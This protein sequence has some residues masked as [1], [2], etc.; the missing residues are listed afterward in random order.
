[1]TNKN[2][3]NLLVL[4]NLRCNDIPWLEDKL[5][6]QLKLH[7][8]WTSLS[9]QNEILEIISHSVVQRITKDVQLSRNYALI[10]DKTS[11]ISCT[12]LNVLD[13]ITLETFLGFFSTI[14][15]EGEVLFELV[16]KV[17]TDHGGLS[18][19][20]ECLA[21]NFK[22]FHYIKNANC[23]QS[24]VILSKMPHCMVPKCTNGWEKTKASDIT[25]HRVPSGPTKSIW[26]RN[27]RRDNPHKLNNSFVCS[28]HFTSECFIPA[29]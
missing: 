8:Q 12:E 9:I 28:V 3:G 14:S 20:T 25:Y 26:L 5:K 11:D 24:N 19:V 23:V 7:A 15:T 1:M 2:R 13:G 27:I 16:K 4:L 18:D 10:M 6:S 29:T 21:R 17:M 22:N